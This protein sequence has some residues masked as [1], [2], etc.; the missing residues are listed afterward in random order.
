[1]AIICNRLQLYRLWHWCLFYS[2]RATAIS[3][4]YTFFKKPK[5]QIWTR[6]TIS[7]ATRFYVRMMRAFGLLSFEFKNIDRL[8]NS[9]ELIIANHPSLLDVCF[10][11]YQSFR[12]LAA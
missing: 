1:M 6:R 8:G 11:Y 7:F 5:K 4:S 10:L 2:H 12:M 3:L 9:G